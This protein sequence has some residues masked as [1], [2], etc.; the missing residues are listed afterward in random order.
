M[1]KR[2]ASVDSLSQYGCLYTAL[3]L[4]SYLSGALCG[5]L[6][7][8]AS[9]SAMGEKLSVFCAAAGESFSTL[10]L[11]GSAAVYFMLTVLLAQLPCGCA[12][13]A[14]L[15]ACKGFCSA[16]ALGLFYQFRLTADLDAELTRFVLHSLLLL[17]ACCAL[18][19]AC[20]ACAG[21]ERNRVDRFSIL[22]PFLYLAALAA[23][24]WMIWG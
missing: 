12:L 17:P 8:R 13:V 19:C 5:L 10:S 11:F 9:V 21:I 15:T 24:E 18:T 7:A 16:Y 4:I 3:W 23:L 14:A 1:Q 2:T 20:C 22:F 6:C